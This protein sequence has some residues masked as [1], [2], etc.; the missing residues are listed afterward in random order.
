M[1]QAGFIEVSRTESINGI[2]ARFHAPAASR[3]EVVGSGSA[4]LRGAFKD[5]I[6]K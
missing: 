6:V 1:E 3:Y 5:S 4:V 2:L